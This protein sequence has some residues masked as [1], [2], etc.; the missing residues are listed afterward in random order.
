MNLRGRFRTEEGGQ[1]AFYCLR[2]ASYEIPR[3]GAAGRVLRAL[4]REAWRPGHVHFIV[5]FLSPSFSLTVVRRKE[6]GRSK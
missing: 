3:D 1:Y 5:G 6:V 4:D 2:P